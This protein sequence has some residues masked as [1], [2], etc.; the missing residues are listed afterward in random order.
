M[1]L[2][3]DFSL[4]GAGFPPLSVTL[5]VQV[6]NRLSCTQLLHTIG[7]LYVAYTILVAYITILVATSLLVTI[8]GGYI[9]ETIVGF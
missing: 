3:G 7:G 8:I 1:Q 2:L 9:C 4:E 5:S 6:N